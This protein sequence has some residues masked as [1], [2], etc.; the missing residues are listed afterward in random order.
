MDWFSRLI[1]SSVWKW[2]YLGLGVKR[3]LALLFLGIT[4]LSLSAG[5]MLVNIYRQAPLPSVFYYV[6]LQFME[7]WERG[8]L[9]GVLGL[10]L[11][12]LAIVKLSESLL[13]AF[14]D[15]DTDIADALYR[16]R[17]RRR[18]PKIVAIGG[19]TGLSTLLRG[20]KDYTDSLTAIVTV[21][22]D[23][24]SSGRLRRELGVLP[25]GD[26]RQCI[27]ALAD[28]EPLMTQLLQ[29]RFGEGSGLEGHSFG[30]L[31]IAAMAGITGDFESALLESSRVL[32]VRGKILPSTL[33]SVVLCAETREPATTGNAL[34]QVKGESEITHRGRPIDRVY[35]EPEHVP[36]YPGAVRAILDADLII[37]GPG[38]LYTSVLPN[39]LVEEIRSALEVSR[40]AKVYIC[41][42]ATQP[43]ETDDF[44]VEDHVEALSQHV[45]EGIFEHVIA[46]DN[47]RVSFPDNPRSQM[48]HP[49][50]D[51]ADGHFGM[52]LA[53]MVDESK[54]WRHDPSKLARAVLAWYNRSKT[55]SPADSQE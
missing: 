37:A 44:T 34:A 5:L 48:V 45:G 39:L 7:R 36:A 9:L 22:D 6:T 12:A 33:K 3:W 26:F 50:G 54:P 15:S 1:K 17:T 25:P 38:S 52:T 21:A 16:K 43:G 20:L 35:L 13:S 10:V 8:V 14:V 29:Y 53:D 47:W 4:I 18:G 42:V 31:F 28:S 2:L 30:N 41:N 19:G 23:G 11:A 40:A 51:G 55:S 32:A 27:A 49:R 24:G 46:N